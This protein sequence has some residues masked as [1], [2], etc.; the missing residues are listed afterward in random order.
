[1]RQTAEI[2]R[3]AAA[4]GLPKGGNNA[5]L[6]VSM[7]LAKL[8]RARFAVR[9]QTW[10]LSDGAHDQATSLESPKEEGNKTSW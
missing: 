4:T 5:Q 3:R 8:S 7:P 1:M 9:I 10:L 2:R 6:Y